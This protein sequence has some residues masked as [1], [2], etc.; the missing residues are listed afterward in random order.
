MRGSCLYTLWASLLLAA[1]CCCV[2]PL[3]QALSRGPPRVSASPGPL[4]ASSSLLSPGGPPVPSDRFAVKGSPFFEAVLP[5]SFFSSHKSETRAVRTPQSYVQLGVGRKLLSRMRGSVSNFRKDLRRKRQLRKKTSS[6]LQAVEAGLGSKAD[7]VAV[8]EMLKDQTLLLPRGRR[9][10]LGHALSFRPL[11]LYQQVRAQRGKLLAIRFP[12]TLSPPEEVSKE[13]YLKEAQDAEGRRKLLPRGLRKHTLQVTNFG[14]LQGPHDKVFAVQFLEESVVNVGELLEPLV[15]P[16]SELPSS[17]LEKSDKVHLSLMAASVARRSVDSRIAFPLA[18]SSSFW[19]TASGVVKFADTREASEVKGQG[20]AAIA[21]ARAA[22]RAATAPASPAAAAA[23]PS[24]K[25]PY[26][27]MA[28]AL[29]WVLYNLWCQPPSEAAAPG[30]TTPAADAAAAEA[31]APGAAAASA[32][33]GGAEAA[34]QGEAAPNEGAAAAAPVALLQKLPLR[35]PAFIENPGFE[36]TPDAA[37]ANPQQQQQPLQQNQQQQQQQQTQ[38]DYDAD[39]TVDEPDQQEGQDTQPSQ[40]Q[41]Q[42]QQQQPQPQQ[43]RLQPQQS[44]QPQRPQQPQQPQQQLQQQQVQ[45]QLPQQP[46]PQQQQA[47]KPQPLQQFFGG[48]FQEEEVEDERLREDASR[49]A[50]LATCSDF[51]IAVV[52][53][54]LRRGE[55]VQGSINAAYRLFRKM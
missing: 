35:Q 2:L 52:I 49:L 40:Q 14:R 41:P 33:P 44:Q 9:L 11:F 15:S 47:Q 23:Q 28:R 8:Q 3:A 51:H 27:P 48:G 36:P 43:P 30:A 46:Q 10:S 6:L 50:D 29:F 31:P 12:I 18:N 1:C 24:R 38:Q 16:L 4:G 34:P 17:L 45:E 54:L 5:A 25:N 32:A 20:K 42:Q 55:D 19:L 7:V 26:R 22:L 13:E 21:G 53:Q 37:P 39:D